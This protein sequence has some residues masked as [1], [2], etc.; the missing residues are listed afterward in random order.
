MKKLFEHSKYA[1]VYCCCIFEFVAVFDAEE[2][3][4]FGGEDVGS[5]L[6]LQT[7]SLNQCLLLKLHPN[8][9]YNKLNSC[10][11]RQVFCTFSIFRSPP[12]SKEWVKSS[13][14]RKWPNTS[15]LIS[16]HIYYIYFSVACFLLMPRVFF[17]L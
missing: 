1:K 11:A 17:P 14:F 3:S 12:L 10:K 6:A 2:S 5:I 4:P 7:T 13:S 9:P 15:T 8:P 16:G